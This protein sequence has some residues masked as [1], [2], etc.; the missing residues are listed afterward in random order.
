MGVASGIGSD[1]G[2]AVASGTG[3]RR[4]GEP[5][6]R[7]HAPSA[8]GGDLRRFWNLTFTLA[9]TD[10]RMT[11]F[12]SAL[13]YLWSLMQPLMY[14]SVLYVVF[15][16]IFK[17]QTNPPVKHYAVYML[18]GI[19]LW[20]FFLQTT[21]TSVQCL[22]ARE[23]LLRKMRFPRLVVPLAVALTA[24]FQLGMNF[25]AVIIFAL[26]SGITPTIT[27]LELPVLVVLMAILAVGT[28]M[29]LSC[30]YIR[31]RDIAPIWGVVAQILFYGSPV[32]YTAAKYPAGFQRIALCNP[33]A[34]INTQMEHAFVD[35]GAHSAARMIGGSVRLAIPLGII[36]GVFAL[37]AWF[38]H[39]EAPRIAENL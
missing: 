12:G 18:T 33:I 39:R 3:S 23:G 9:S 29:I 10:F 22:L 25:I 16:K 17:V 30:L 15:T 28:G 38:F 19:V 7:R 31:Y 36:F 20:T 8:I 27:W 26:L 24:L 11:Y 1:A 2:M 5:V 13:G 6:A 35:P 34:A 37:G 32:I 14:F 4:A 21:S